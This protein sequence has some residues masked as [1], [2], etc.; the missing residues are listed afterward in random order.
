MLDITM[1]SQMLKRI[2]IITYTE[3]HIDAPLLLSSLKFV[4]FK[5]PGLGYA[6]KLKLVKSIF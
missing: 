1:H 2:D 6:I 3:F 5:R 4:E